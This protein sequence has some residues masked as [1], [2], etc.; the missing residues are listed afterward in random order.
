MWFQNSAHVCVVIRNRKSWH[1]SI[2]LFIPMLFFAD[3]KGL[4]GR[5][6]GL[7][8]CMEI[9]WPPVPM[10]GKLLSG[11]KKMVL[12]KRPMNTLGMIHQ[13]WIVFYYEAE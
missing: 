10:I 2:F 3:M 4:Y 6:L 8:Q 13:V 5:L 12:G 7:I 9:S 11:R 1:T